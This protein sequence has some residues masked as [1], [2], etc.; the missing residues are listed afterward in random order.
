MGLRSSSGRIFSIQADFVEANKMVSARLLLGCRVDIQHQVMAG[1]MSRYVSRDDSPRH[2]RGEEGGYIEEKTE[3]IFSVLCKNPGS[4]V[5]G[6]ACKR[7]VAVHAH[8]L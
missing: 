8:I 7:G 1:S 2:V 4:L 5:S 6:D 3:R